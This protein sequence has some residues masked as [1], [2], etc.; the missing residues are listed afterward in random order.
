MSQEVVQID[1]RS[2]VWKWVSLAWKLCK[3]T[4]P[5]P[6]LCYGLMACSHNIKCIPGVF[7]C[8]PTA[9]QTASFT[10]EW[11][12]SS[13][14]FFLYQLLCQMSQSIRLSIKCRKSICQEIWK[15]P[16][17]QSS[18]LK[19]L[20]QS[21]RC[22]KMF[23]EWV[24]LNVVSL[25]FCESTLCLNSVYGDNVNQN[26]CVWVFPLTTQALH[27]NSIQRPNAM[28]TQCLK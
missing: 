2:C 7:C 23:T 19:I 13:Q 11:L 3:M 24:T 28:W 4:W 20:Q 16:S 5:E 18:V 15:L 8:V 26:R 14:L 10:S 12:C 22:A 25:L 17:A 9:H 6:L 21:I 1:E 27:A